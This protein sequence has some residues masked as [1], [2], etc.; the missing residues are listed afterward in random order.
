MAFGFAACDNYEEP[1]PPAQSNTQSTVVKPEDVTF[2]NTLKADQVYSLSAYN[3][4]GANVPVAT[5]AGPNLGEYYAYKVVAQI[6]ADGFN[7]F[8][9]VATSVDAANEEGTVYTVS[10][11][12]ANFQAAY[13]QAITKDPG[14][15][16]IQIRYALYT[17]SKGAAGSQDAQIGTSFYGPY[18]FSLKPY[19][20]ERVIEPNYYI[21]GTASDFEMTQAVKLNHEGNQYDNP[22]FSYKF[23]LT[24]GWS[25]KIVPESTFLTG[26]FLQADG[27][28]FGPAIPDDDSLKGD[29]VASTLVDGVYTE[30]NYG[31][32]GETG[33]YMFTVNMETLKFEVSFAVDNLWTPGNSNGW[34]HAASQL[35][36]TNDYT[37]YLGMAHLSGE[38]KFSV[39][40]DWNGLS[41][42]AGKTEGTLSKEGD[43]GNLNAGADGLYWCNVNLVELTYTLTPITAVGL[44]GDACPNGWDASTPLTPSA[45]FLK[46]T[47][48]VAMKG[49]G[50][51]K[52]R[53]NDAWDID[54]GGNPQDLN[55]KDNNIATP[56]E[57]TYDV[58]V[59]FSVL[60]YAITF[61][62]K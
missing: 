38:F 41:Y 6:S 34:S 55:F 26:D 15:K 35:L 54:F 59:D 27:S 22:I 33:P 48:T 13:Q 2:S 9:E 37:T 46:W 51:Y 31:Q 4:E 20:P 8:A 17:T 49:T 60:P 32:L 44:I 40:P 3:A 7:K 14:T 42:G 62:K 23:D 43:A 28:E 57:G 50:E 24:P 21:V 12:P 56:G 58:T 61:S 18:D 30:A 25:W 52:I 45:D 11:V 47:G 16:Q 5:V 19:D 39:Q 10:V 1:N 53:C 29:L 36:Y